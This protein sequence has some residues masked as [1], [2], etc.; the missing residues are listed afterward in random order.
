MSDIYSSGT[1]ILWIKKAG[2]LRLGKTK[3]GRKK[4]FCYNIL[5]ILKEESWEQTFSGFQPIYFWSKCA[6][7][8]KISLRHWHLTLLMWKKGVLS[9]SCGVTC[10]WTKMLL[11]ER[12]V[13]RDSITW[14]VGFLIFW[15][16]LYP[17]GKQP[18]QSVWERGGHTCKND[19]TDYLSTSQISLTSSRLRL[20]ATG[21]VSCT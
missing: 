12:Q 17:S 3:G 13:Q 21:N 1:S 20:G 18:R 2:K 7:E 19:W 16:F 11:H 5:K 15:D 14:H 10:C 4:H 6:D 9:L 8:F